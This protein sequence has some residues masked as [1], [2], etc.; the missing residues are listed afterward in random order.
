MSGNNQEQAWKD[1]CAMYQQD[2]VSERLLQWQ[3]QRDL[4]V[5]RMLLAVWLYTHEQAVSPLTE[6]CRQLYQTVIKPWRQIRTGVREMSAFK[7]F[8][9]RLLQ[10]ELQLER[11]YFDELWRVVSIS[12]DREEDA[13]LSLLLNRLGCNDVLSAL[14]LEWLIQQGYS[15]KEKEG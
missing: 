6:E 2:G 12:P 8:Y 15:I 14:E 7:G 1:I 9:R 10:L 3:H 13:S 5:V 11:A 4:D